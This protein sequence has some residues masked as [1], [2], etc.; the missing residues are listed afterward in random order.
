METKNGAIQIDGL[1]L[2]CNVR[3]ASTREDFISN[4]EGVKKDLTEFLHQFSPEAKLVAAPSIFWGRK[5]LSGFPT[6]ATALGCQPDYNAWDDGNRN[7]TPDPNQQFRTGAGHVHVSWT[8]GENTRSKA[9]LATCCK[10]VKELDYTLGLPSL[11]WDQDNRRRSLYGKA[12]AFRPKPYGLEYRVLSN[13]WT[14]KPK[15]IG[16][17][18]DTTIKTVERVLGGWENSFSHRFGQLAQTCI[19]NN[20]NRWPELWP[21]IADEV[22][23]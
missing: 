6:H 1:A 14:E 2:E 16:W 8:E 19:N 15:H 12:G 17:V 3:P 20:N 11:L 5:R 7:P 22:L 13:K 9:F 23:Q 10:I 21:G 4:M 18:F